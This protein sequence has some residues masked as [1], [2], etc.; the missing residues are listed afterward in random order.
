MISVYVC[1]LVCLSACV[2]QKP[3]VQISPIFLYM[4]PV[5]VARSSSDGSAMG[6]VL[7]VLWMTSRFHIMEGTDPNQRQR[8]LFLLV[9]QVAAPGRSLPSPTASCL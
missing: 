4:L 6:Y 7:P 5:A 9:R 1:L 3:H 8:V 2:S